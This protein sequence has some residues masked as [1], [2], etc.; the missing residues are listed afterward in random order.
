MEW[1]NGRMS[2]TTATAAL[3]GDATFVR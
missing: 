2:E 3:R 1:N